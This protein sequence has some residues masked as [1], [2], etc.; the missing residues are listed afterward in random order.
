MGV[1]GAT[2]ISTLLANSSPLQA[3]EMAF[4]S[5]TQRSF[6][7]SDLQYSLLVVANR[8]G[9]GALQAQLR[10]PQKIENV[11]EMIRRIQPDVWR[12]Y[13]QQ[14]F[15][16]R[17]T[18]IFSL[19]P[20]DK[21][22]SV[23]VGGGKRKQKRRPVSKS[24]MPKEIVS[25]MAA[26]GELPQSSGA[27]DYMRDG[28]PMG[29]YL[30]SAGV[31]EKR[32][33]KSLSEVQ[34]VLILTAMDVERDAI[35][36]QNDHVRLSEENKTTLDLMEIGNRKIYVSKTGVGFVNAT[37]N[38]VKL[39]DKYKFDAV[40]LVGVGGALD[41]ALNPGDVVVADGVVQHDTV[42]V[43]ENGEHLMAPGELFMSIPE[44]ERSEPII[45]PDNFLEGWIQNAFSKGK[46]RVSVYKGVIASGNSFASTTEKKK[47]IAS[48][49]DDSM[50]VDMEAG[51]V[52]QVAASH[53][54]PFAVVKTVSDT[55]EPQDGISDE[56][57]TFVKPASENAALVVKSLVE[58]FKKDGDE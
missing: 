16:N 39:Y 58:A 22:R 43:D 44:E 35:L 29:V 12:T 53:N 30:K 25:A 13:L 9:N 6:I 40:I 28:G 42:F 15:S 48:R 23:V 57:T 36:N 55:L 50:L 32:E 5:M 18:S 21:L 14:P 17:R 19:K 56:Y 27:L 51:A 2:Y 46:D 47:K 8:M 3:A 10:N 37:V 26:F 24:A 20:T 11:Y 52:A 7:G 54:I 1:T 34:S 33:L 41:A 31:G 49:Y 4:N 38:M 45:R